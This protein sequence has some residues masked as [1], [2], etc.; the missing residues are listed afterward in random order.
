[1]EVMMTYKLVYRLYTKDPTSQWDCVALLNHDRR[2]MED[3]VH[4][5]SLVVAGEQ[6]LNYLNSVEIYQPAI[7]EW[8]MLS[9]LNQG[10]SDHAL[11]SCDL[12][13]DSC[14]LLVVVVV[15]DNYFVW[16]SCD[17][18]TKAKLLV[19]RNLLNKCFHRDVHLLLFL[20]INWSV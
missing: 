5:G 11:V 4:C 12:P 10:W 18:R 8:K 14:M 17:Y 13:G 6:R 15:R 16:K 20:A 2:A 19:Y 3:T 7:N 1:V 9:P